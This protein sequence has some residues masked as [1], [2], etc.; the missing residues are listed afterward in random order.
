MITNTLSSNLTDSLML[1]RDMG[2]A[3]LDHH[4]KTLCSQINYGRKALS[5]V[6]I[7]D[8]ESLRQLIEKAEKRAAEIE[9][10]C[11]YAS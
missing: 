5:A 11:D 1:E 10:V 2:Q 8:Q 4:R 3:M 7:D 6:W 9:M